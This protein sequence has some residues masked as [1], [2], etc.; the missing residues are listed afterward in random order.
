[1]ANHIAPSPAGAIGPGVPLTERWRVMVP[2]VSM[3]PTRPG[4]VN[5]IPASGPASTS[6]ALVVGA[7]NF[8]TSPAG[9]RRPT[10]PWP[11]NHTAPSGP[12]VIAPSAPE[13]DVNE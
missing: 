3:R 11:A 7:G 10:N 13:A 1:M 9:V 12:E 6:D 4:P 2:D 5:Q 8:C